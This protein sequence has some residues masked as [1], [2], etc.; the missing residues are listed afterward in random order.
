MKIQ[1]RQSVFETNSS[2][3]HTITICDRSD[4][5]DW[6]D[7]IKMFQPCSNKFLPN[8]QAL[9]NNTKCL[10]KFKNDEEDCKL[11]GELYLTYKEYIDYYGEEYETFS[12]SYKDVV[13]FGYY[14]YD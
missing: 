13:A 5:K 6:K 2:S 1:I 8:E 4:F 14:G 7:D 3:V 9:K 12:S 10:K 11:F